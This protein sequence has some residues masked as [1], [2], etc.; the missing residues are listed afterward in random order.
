MGGTAVLWP[1]VRAED[2]VPAAAAARGQVAV[3]FAG[4]DGGQALRL[5]RHVS[6]PVLPRAQFPGE[7]AAAAQRKQS[8]H[9]ASRRPSTAAA[10]CSMAGTEAVIHIAAAV[11]V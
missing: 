6:G 5:D 4:P 3:Q 1:A 8:V 10:D 2:A 11:A 9:S 7:I